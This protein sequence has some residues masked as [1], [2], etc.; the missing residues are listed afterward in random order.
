MPLRATVC[1][2][3]GVVNH[4]APPRGRSA[5][6]VGRRAHRWTASRLAGQDAQAADRGRTTR[7]LCPQ[8]RTDTV[9]APAEHRLVGADDRPRCPRRALDLT[10]STSSPAP[11]RHAAAQRCAATA[12]GGGRRSRRSSRGTPAPVASGSRS[13]RRASIVSRESSADGSQRPRAA[14]WK[15]AAARVRRWEMP[16]TL[17]PSIGDLARA[18]AGEAHRRRPRRCAPA[19]PCAPSPS[20][21]SSASAAA[22]TSPSQCDGAADV[23]VPQR[24]AGGDDHVDPEHLAGDD[25]H[26]SPAAAPPHDVDVD[27]RPHVGRPA[28]RCRARAPAPV[29]SATHTARSAGSGTSSAWKSAALSER[30]STRQL[31]RDERGRVEVGLPV[32]RARCRRRPRPTSSRGARRAGGAGPSWSRAAAGRACARCTGGTRPPRS[33]S[34]CSPPRLRGTTWSMLSAAWPQY[35]QRWSSRA[36]T[37]RRFSGARRRYGTFTKWRSRITDGTASVRCSECSASPVSWR[38]SALCPSTSTAARRLGTTQS[39]S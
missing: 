24:V 10:P 31:M 9:V 37:P 13:L 38:M 4:F 30:R 6:F 16:T 2:F 3:M 20:T 34:V 12:G 17:R 7:A 19:G 35:W 32:L 33:P 14:H 36:N 26:R 1:L 23:V 27:A 8:T 28:A 22:H 5:R 11:A 21:P 29:G 25:E 15:R 39:G 18:E